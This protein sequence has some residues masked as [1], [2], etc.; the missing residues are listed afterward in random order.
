MRSVRRVVGEAKMEVD[1]GNKVSE[2]MEVGG[3]GGKESNKSEQGT[4]R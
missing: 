1:K 3:G 4:G 2:V